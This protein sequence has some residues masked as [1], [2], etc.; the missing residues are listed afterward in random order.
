MSYT[1]KARHRSQSESIELS[2]C[3]PQQDYILAVTEPEPRTHHVFVEKTVGAVTTLALS[4][5]HTFV[6]ADH[7]TGHI[8]SS[9]SASLHVPAHS[10]PPTMLAAVASGCKD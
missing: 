5:D 2:R 7:A 1:L 6:M 9:T 10:I 4:H 3:L 8:H